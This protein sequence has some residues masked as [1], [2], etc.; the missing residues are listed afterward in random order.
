MIKR[1]AVQAVVVRK[2]PDDGYYGRYGGK[3]NLSEWRRLATQSVM[4]LLVVVA[5]SLSF[6]EQFRAKTEK[7]VLADNT[8]QKKTEKKK[9]GKETVTAESKTTV[10]AAAKAIQPQPTQQPQA[11]KQKVVVI[12]AGHGG[13]DEGTS[14]PDRKCVEKKY[15]LLI[16]E[17]VIELLKEQGVQVYATRTSDK[18][19]SKKSRV[20]TVKK[21]K[22]DL[23][24]SI[25]CNASTVGDY[26]SNGIEVLYAKKKIKGYDLTNKQLADI[27]MDSLSKTSKL[28]K[29]KVIQR[30]NLYLLHYSKVPT[31]IVEIGYITN[32][33]DMKY[34]MKEKGQKETAQ[35]ICD[36][37]LKAL[38]AGK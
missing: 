38:E 35:G 16:S 3:M 32:K 8:S 12:D 19:V 21:K 28:E 26:T 13:M 18:M 34:I 27:L 30:S 29:R 4:L 11:E 7:T 22:A 37:I 36:G 5:C 20:G 31:A 25:H 9:A 6:S 15:T 23:F 1:K 17:K 10:K 24:V 2:K 33:K 14:S